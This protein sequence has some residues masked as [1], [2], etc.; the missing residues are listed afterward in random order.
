MLTRYLR[1]AL[2]LFMLTPVLL[3]AVMTNI[4][5]AWADERE[6]SWVVDPDTNAARLECSSNE[7]IPGG[8]GES[9]V[10]GSSTCTYQGKEI[11]CTGPEGSIWNGACYVGQVM[12]S[13]P[14]ATGPNGEE[15]PTEGQFHF[16]YL[17]PGVQGPGVTWVAVGTPP[18][19]DPEV[20]AYRAIAGMDL[21]P[22]GVGIVPE[23]G[24]DKRGFVGLPTW[25]WVANPTVANAWGPITATAT[26]G[27]VTVTATA[28]VD[29]VAWDMGDGTPPVICGEGTPYSPGYGKSDSPTCG[30]RYEHV[31]D[32][33]P[34]GVFKVRAATAWTVV[35]SGAG[36]EGTISITTTTRP[37]PIR[38]S[39]L[40]VLKQ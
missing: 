17:A 36:M 2:V 39:E 6:C 28:T 3:A 14:G 18:P 33:Q 5:H 34:K 11:P 40:Q 37:V 8:E 24:P 27:P 35:W 26:D 4:P 38:I 29:E 7:S 12:P 20:L 31:S 30:H 22:I 32:S 15:I 23:S 16:C 13:S 1:G 19:V 21:D 10:S 9:T 25:M